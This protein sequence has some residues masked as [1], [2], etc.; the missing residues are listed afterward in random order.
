MGDIFDITRDRA[1]EYDMDDRDCGH[2][3]A[4]CL[5]DPPCRRHANPDRLQMVDELSRAVHG[6]AFARPESPSEVWQEL[7]GDVARL[8][9]AARDR[10][11]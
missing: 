7:I 2:Q 6:D 4:G 11:S 1:D 3:L 8:R 9:R 5:Y 10:K